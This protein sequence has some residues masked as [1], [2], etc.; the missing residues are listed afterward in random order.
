[1]SG[2]AL[3]TLALACACA[4]CDGAEGASDCP[5]GT[6][7]WQRDGEGDDSTERWCRDTDTGLAHGPYQ[8]TRADL[9]LAAGAFD[10]GRADGAWRWSDPAGGAEAEVE[11]A[12]VL[13]LPDGAWSAARA[14]GTPAWEH[15]WA[16]GVPCGLWRDWLDGELVS[17][18][19]RGDCA[20][21]GGGEIPPPPPGP[22]WDGETCPA[23]TDVVV[24]PP[25]RWCETAAG[26]REGAYRE[27]GPDGPRVEG[28]YAGGLQTGTWRYLFPGG[29]LEGTGAY[30]AGAREGGWT[31]YF[32]RGTPREK[33][34]Y[35][36]GARAGAYERFHAN[37]NPAESGD[38][39]AD[40]RQGLWTTWHAAG[41][42]ALEGNWEHG[43]RVGTWR[44]WGVDGRLESEVPWVAGGQWGHATFWF[45]HAI[46]GARVRDQGQVFDG[47]AFGLWTMTW[48]AGGEPA[49]E[50]RYHE[51]VRQGAFFELWPNGSKLIEGFFIDGLLNHRYRVWYENGQL[52]LDATM[53]AGRFSGHYV[54]YWDNG[55]KKAEGAYGTISEKVG[56]WKY[57]DRD[58]K[59]LGSAPAGGGA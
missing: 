37:G 53:L 26:L 19:E 29:A 44:G 1:M 45:D 52:N 57:W 30:V 6:Q 8:R 56:A 46:T 35:A 4:A 34:T 49:G 3:L 13:G 11:G 15:A 42:R 40:Q 28:Q 32:A 16:M 39:A 2:R 51:G 24:A 12:F 41:P 43:L 38:Y 14:D 21:A 20:T 23:G 36:G 22:A 47:Y 33:V 10:Q 48:E 31:W 17:E 27:D 18:V 50:R 9:V 58:G 54:E 5:P 59:A 55:Q 25:E 7:A